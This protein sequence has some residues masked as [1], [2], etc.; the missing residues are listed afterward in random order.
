MGASW[1]PGGF[2][3]VDVF[4]VISG[5]LITGILA[6]EIEAGRFSL[7]RFYLRRA[8]R[9]LPALFL[10]LTATFAIG[11]I[12]LSPNELRNL[13]KMI[14]GT[15][16]FASNVLFLRESGYFAAAAERK[17]LLMTWSLGIEEQFY[18]LWP[19]T[20]A[21]LTK[22]RRSLPAA[23]GAIGVASFGIACWEVSRS[24]SAAFYLL[25]GRAWELL[26]GA[27][28]AIQPEFLA[29]RR[30]SGA[31]GHHVASLVGLVLIAGSVL[32]L[33]Q[34]SA[35]PAWN[36][37][38]SCIGA[39]LL[40]WAGEDAVGNRF[41]LSSRPLVFIGLISYP[42]Y[43]WHW[44][45]LSFAH[46]INGPVLKV[47]LLLPLV[48]LALGLSILTWRYLETPLREARGAVPLV[49]LTRYGILTGAFICLGTLTYLANGFPS[50]AAA[51]FLK[52]DAARTD[53]NP[54]RASCLR[55]LGAGVPLGGKECTIRR[56][57]KPL[58]AVW[59]DSHGDGIAPG[60]RAWAERNGYGFVQL[61]AKAC[62]PLPG[63]H[64]VEDREILR[65]C[66]A[67]NAQVTDLLLADIEI[68]TVFL[69]ARWALYTENSRFG[70]DPGAAYYLVAEAS[71]ERSTANSRQIFELALVQVVA[72]LRSAGKA[73]VVLGQTPEM[74]HDTP[75][76]Y[77][78]KARFD[79]LG[80]DSET[81]TVAS[82]A[83]SRRLDFTNHVISKLGGG[84]SD[85]RSFL[86]TTVLCTAEECRSQVEGM[87]LYYDDDHLTAAGARYLV[88]RL[89]IEGS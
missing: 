66:D 86:P 15:S 44:P 67:F 49:A 64:V 38:P 50:R 79:R 14:A 9:I 71:E 89:S 68:K 35:F 47:G 82:S 52:A 75:A 39:L 20:L 1:L 60:V 76:C 73:V 85:V 32:R 51:G 43:L 17:P 46:I 48:G 81:C 5:Y 30:H 74:G 53:I 24:S 36:A 4:F 80:M 61:T 42:L 26:L 16:A 72:R 63:A 34:T 56:P 84:N 78:R 28:L 7:I 25:P 23:M 29:N 59:G 33:D 57:G 31:L 54:L 70:E 40:I 19:L 62:P 10:V 45:I 37:L 65:G 8:R 77:E 18:I 11:L 12:L 21:L 6:R 22:W 83:V 69:A 13:G 55:D 58:V 3:G 87:I 2:V 88:D 41:V 27:S